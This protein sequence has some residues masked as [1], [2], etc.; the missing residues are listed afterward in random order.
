M[1][2][3]NAEL[4]RAAKAQGTVDSWSAYGRSMVRAGKTAEAL[5]EILDAAASS[6]TKT[7]V[8]NCWEQDKHLVQF[9]LRKNAPNTS[10]V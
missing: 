10:L 4:L 6:V 8:E 1:D 9:Y 7:L 3:K 2:G 5:Q